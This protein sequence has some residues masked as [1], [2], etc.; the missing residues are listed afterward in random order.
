MQKIRPN[1]SRAILAA[2][3]FS[4]AASGAAAA[5]DPEALAPL[6]APPKINEARAKL[7][8]ILFFDSRLAGDTSS[9]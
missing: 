6:P 4:A 3:L 1:R 2:A 8:S 7:G 9:S 5:A